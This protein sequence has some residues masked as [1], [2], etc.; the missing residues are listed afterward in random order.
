MQTQVIIKKNLHMEHIS[1]NYPVEKGHLK[2][3]R[4]ASVKLQG[5]KLVGNKLHFI[6]SYVLYRHFNK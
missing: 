1:V 5:G 3:N 6:S 4:A 2:L